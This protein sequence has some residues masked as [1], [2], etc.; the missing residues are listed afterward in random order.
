MRSSAKDD[1]FLESVFL[2]MG[3][4]S[5]S[6][7]GTCGDER[8]IAMMSAN[9]LG[10]DES[11][12]AKAMSY[13][14][15]GADRDFNP[16]NIIEKFKSIFGR[17]K[18]TV[19]RFIEFQI[20]LAYGDRN[21]CENERARLSAIARKLG[22][23]DRDLEGIEKSVVAALHISEKANSPSPGHASNISDADAFDALRISPSSTSAATKAAYLD[24]LK[25]LDPENLR[26]IGAPEPMIE[27]AIQQIEAIKIAYK[28]IS[29]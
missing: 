2:I 27:A 29:A 16:D 3:Y 8:M 7:G 19:T 9:K 20:R 28:H 15:S 10:L 24:L 26:R 23:E 22:I 6:D 14:D 12:R 13:F 11:T 25:D 18:K 1:V 17:D 4:V 5:M 21:L